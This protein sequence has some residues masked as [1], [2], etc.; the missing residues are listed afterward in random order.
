MWTVRP[1]KNVATRH[2]GTIDRRKITVTPSRPRCPG[3]RLWNQG[4]RYADTWKWPVVSSTTMAR[5]I[6]PDDVFAALGPCP[7]SQSHPRYPLPPNATV[8]QA[9][10]TSEHDDSGFVSCFRVLPPTNGTKQSW[11]ARPP[12]DNNGVGWTH[13][14]ACELNSPLGWR[15]PVQDQDRSSSVLPSTG[16]DQP[17]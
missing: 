11:P 2:A 8:P 14:G 1:T 4:M 6:G 5:K 13:A 12:Q 9:I 7:T 17:I 3:E 15:R 16:W 10:R